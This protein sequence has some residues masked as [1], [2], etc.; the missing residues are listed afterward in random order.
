M[1]YIWL[2]PLL[3][4]V[5]VLFVAVFVVNR[6]ETGERKSGTVVLKAPEEDEEDSAR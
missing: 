1:F 3:L 5:M 2:V 6:P 4:L